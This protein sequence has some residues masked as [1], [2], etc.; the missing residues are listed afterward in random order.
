MKPDLFSIPGP[1][2][3]KLA[4]AG[5]PPGYD[6]PR[7][8]FSDLRAG[9]SALVVSI[10]ESDDAQQLGLADEREAATSEGVEFIS[11][12]IPDRGVPASAHEALSLINVVTSA[13]QQGRNV[14][15]HCR[16]GLGRAGMIAASV[17]VG[18]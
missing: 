11:F 16:Q 1:W 2:R 14:A 10:L 3:G 8:E 5:R 7:H 4:I 17:L 9:G 15:I 18:A 13:L 12:P 6:W